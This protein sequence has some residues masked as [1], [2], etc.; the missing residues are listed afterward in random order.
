MPSVSSERSEFFGRGLQTRL[1]RKFVIESM[2][3]AL[4]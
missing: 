2:E 3:N 4:I 1:H